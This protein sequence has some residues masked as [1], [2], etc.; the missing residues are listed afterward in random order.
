MCAKTCEFIDPYWFRSFSQIILSFHKINE[1]D[2]NISSKLPAFQW[3]NVMDSAQLILS[4]WMPNTN[5]FFSKK[6]QPIQPK[7]RIQ[8]NRIK[9]NEKT[10]QK[11]KSELAVTSNSDE[12]R[13]FQII[14]FIYLGRTAPK[15]PRQHTQLHTSTIFSHTHTH[16]HTPQTQPKSKTKTQTPSMSNVCKHQSFQI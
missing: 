3:G 13:S 10:E 1:S 14:L 11:A 2:S 7:R 16:T 15:Q 5:V 9:E 6:I 4:D 8:M 12:S